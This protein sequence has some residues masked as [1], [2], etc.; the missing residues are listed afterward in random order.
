[1]GKGKTIACL[2][3]A[4]WLAGAASAAVEAEAIAMMDGPNGSGRSLGSA[5]SMACGPQQR[6]VGVRIYEDGRVVTGIEALCATLEQGAAGAVVWKGLP[7]VPE[8]P[9]R[10]PLQ[11]VVV[12][13]E[14]ADER[15]ETNVLRVSSSGTKRFKGSRAMLITVPSQPAASWTQVPAERVTLNTGRTGRDVVCAEGQ[16]VKGLRTGTEAGR[17]GGLVAVQLLCGTG[18]GRVELVGSWVETKKSNKNRAV[19]A[20]VAMR[21]QCGGGVANPH[22]GAAAKALIGTA[23]DGRVVSLGVT[24]AKSAVPGVVSLAVGAVS[25]WLSDVV[26]VA[27]PAAMR[28]YRAPNWYAG[29]DVAVCR[30][31]SG[32]GPC[33]QASA[34][35]FCVTMTGA[36]RASFYVVGR[37]SDDA[38]AAGGKRCPSGVCRAFQQ[39]TCAG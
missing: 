14:G 30:D 15:A 6:L 25:R 3:A 28:V 9:E 37:V 36:G 1:M 26:P 38:I 2:A 23:E 5:W 4:V 12:P 8:L 22:D 35:R 21:T 18:N 34:D 19:R 31:G 29:F 10:M 20:I 17:R 7:A 24:C 13:V 32:R 16:F 27:K 11:A 39:I 33:A